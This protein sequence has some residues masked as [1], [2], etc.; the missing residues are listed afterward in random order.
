[1]STNRNISV[2]IKQVNSAF[3]NC[4]ND[5]A[6]RHIRGYLANYLNSKP[7][8]WHEW[9]VM[10]NKKYTR[11]PIH[12]TPRYGIYL[13]NW[14]PG[15]STNIHS[16]AEGGCVFGVV[17]GSLLETRYLFK[18]PNIV[19]STV[20][21]LDYFKDEAIYA[22]NTLITN[23]KTLNQLSNKYTIDFNNLNVGCVGYI[24]NGIGLHSIKNNY[25][26]PAHSI[27]VYSFLN[28]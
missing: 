19:T 13:L 21:E 25:I 23:I 15:Q 1:M 28:K 18:N 5:L 2:L 8:D 14:L 20:P 10:D 9:V 26:S 12:L 24:N 17:K 3:T 7:T 22:D 16:H 11:E 4:T 27:H 6:L